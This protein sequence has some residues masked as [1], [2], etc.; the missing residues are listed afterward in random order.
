MDQHARLL[1]HETRA[2]SYPVATARD[3]PLLFV[4]SRTVSKVDVGDCHILDRGGLRANNGDER[5]QNRHHQLGRRRRCPSPDSSGGGV[6]DDEKGF[7]GDVVEELAWRI[8]LFKDVLHYPRPANQPVV[9][10]TVA[11]VVA[12]CPY[13]GSVVALVAPAPVPPSL[14]PAL[15]ELEDAFAWVTFGAGDGKKVQEPRL[16][17]PRGDNS[18]VRVAPRLHSIE[19]VASVVRRKVY[20]HA[21]RELKR[22]RL[23]SLEVNLGPAASRGVGAPVRFAFPR[24]GARAARADSPGVVFSHLRVFFNLSR[25]VGRRKVYCF[26]GRDACKLRLVPQCYIVRVER[27]DVLL[28]AR[29]PPAGVLWVGV[30]PPSPHVPRLAISSEQTFHSVDTVPVIM[31]MIGGGGGGGGDAPIK[32]KRTP[33]QL[34]KPCPADNVGANASSWMGDMIYL[35]YPLREADQA[36]GAASLFFHF[37]PDSCTPPDSQAS[38]SASAAEVIERPESAGPSVIV[39]LRPK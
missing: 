27:P 32:S 1:R 10:R 12:V 23:S 30:W 2:R 36:F 3:L 17:V 6:W 8:E 39:P 14:R 35:I 24:G 9:F 28:A 16:A 25:R 5:V 38:P 20:R 33:V 18:T 26:R 34:S 37:R 31:I 15:L 11:P 21:D 29:V 7:R 13:P 4:N 19:V 22:P